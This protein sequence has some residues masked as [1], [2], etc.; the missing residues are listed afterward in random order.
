MEAVN[1]NTKENI[2][3]G[4]GMKPTLFYDVEGVL[5]AKDGKDIKIDKMVGDKKVF[6]SLKLK[7]DIQIQLGD[8]VKIDKENIIYMK[9]EEKK[10]E[11]NSL[12]KE[13]LIKRL[14]LQDNEE[15][16]SGIEH[17]LSHQIPI[18]KENLESFFMSKKYL[19]E[20]IHN[21]DFDS[22]VKLLDMN[23]DLEE[24]SLQKIAKALAQ[25]KESDEKLSLKE[26]LNLDRKLSY[27]EAEEIAK[28]I[29]GRTMGRDIYDSIMALHKEKLP[30]T[31]ENIERIMEVMD[32]LHH[33]KEYEGET[34]I[35]AFKE[36]LPIN[37]ET[38]YKYKHSYNHDNLNENITSPL[39]ERFTIEKEQSIEELL[40]LLKDINMA[41]NQENIKLLREFIISGVEVTKENF[42]KILN[43]KAYLKELTNLLDEEVTAKLM[44]EGID[45]LKEDI[46]DLVDRIKGQVYVKESK[47]LHGIME[48]LEEIEGLITIT[49]REL[50]S[51]IKNEK[52]FKIENLKEI[53][54]TNVQ[55]SEDVDGKIIE[56]TITISNIFKTLEEL[57]SG[58]IAFAVKRYT[59]ITLNNLYNSQIE[60]T[61]NRV[62]IIEHV[63]KVEENLIRQEYLNAK[64][65]IKLSL[66]E[67]SV[68]DDIEL[69]NLPLEELNQY[70]Y[71][72]TNRYKEVGDL[73]DRIRYLKGKEEFLIPRIMKGDIHMSIGQLDNI[74]SIF[75]YGNGIGNIFDQMLNG[76]NT[77]N[78]DGIK[79]EIQILETKIKDFST[80]LKRG[81]E[82]VKETYKE[83][84][85]SFKDL[86]HSFN[87][88]K[89]NKDENIGK[90]EEYLKLQNQ[91][92]KE[93]LILQVPVSTEKGY[94]NVNLIVPNIRKGIDK[95]N[96]MFYFNL[97]T[98]HLGQVKFNLEVKNDKI[99]IYIETGKDEVILNNKHLLEEGLSRIGYALEKIETENIN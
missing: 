92:S 95:D 68:K 20:I 77:N 13:D 7:E 70:I 12:D 24:D 42:E 45:P 61:T 36:E 37:I 34:L 93:D 98:E 46:R 65:N 28:D 4:Y 64:A 50:L 56:K 33:L 74:N 47:T 31:K 40:S 83:M 78:Y 71:K 76:Q 3:N 14:D 67:E 84:L 44:D 96:M 49:D 73:V 55:P 32:K 23:I 60:L 26:L 8:M 38:L 57:N 6:Y 58:T 81:K 69:E 62:G 88:D 5:V 59:N 35:K 43:M 15:T 25:I 63:S 51:L 80:S 16:R 41:Q 17:L 27:K 66:I 53:I 75:N 82:D 39:Y 1:F 19:E 89:G 54:N 10:K 94:K 21:I 79:E 72:K 99:S 52:D 30:I 97:D 9:V 22:C 91:L 90:V 29:Y 2:I 85:D 86:N 18:T 48:G 87:S 11:Q